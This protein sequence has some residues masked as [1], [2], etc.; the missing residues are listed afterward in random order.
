MNQTSPQLLVGNSFWTKIS[1]P[2]FSILFSIFSG[3][4]T[5]VLFR[6]WNTHQPIFEMVDPSSGWDAAQYR[7][8]YFELKSGNGAETLQP[9]FSQRILTPLFASVLHL[10]PTE[11]FKL[12]SLVF[13]VLTNSILGFVCHRLTGFKGAF[14]IIV[15]MLFYLLS[16]VRSANMVPFIN[17]PSLMFFESLIILV[18]YSRVYALLLVVLPVAMLA[19]ESFW[20]FG[21]MPVFYMI[22]KT[23][24]L[25]ETLTAAEKK[26]MGYFS[27]ATVFALGVKFL[28]PFVFHFITPS[29]QLKTLIKYLYVRVTDP[30]SLTRL[31]AAMFLALAQYTFLAAWKRSTDIKLRLNGDHFAVFS[32]CWLI[33]HVV[34]I[35]FAGEDMTRIFFLGY[36]LYI[37]FFTNFIKNSSWISL[38]LTSVAGLYFQHVLKAIPFPL[39]NVP[40][41]DMK[42]MFSMLMEYAHISIVTNILV[43]GAVLSL[44][45]YQF[46][47]NIDAL[48]SPARA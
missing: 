16:P 35:C 34:F 42:G 27:A 4:I 3:L 5:F 10:P 46:G 47:K 11:A 1:N 23:V 18:L 21:I 8:L 9:P 2:N 20:I 29:S 24:F 14:F 7:A 22:F 39:S 31:L 28:L 36:P 17:D 6:F 41:G 32:I 43:T 25:K 26:L 45:F 12:T 38:V 15:P 30:T 13:I 19:K 37:F 44:F 33:V 48:F 40:D